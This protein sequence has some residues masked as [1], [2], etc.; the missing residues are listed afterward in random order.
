M[1]SGMAAVLLA[2][3]SYNTFIQVQKIA[4]TII[5]NFVCAIRIIKDSQILMK[6]IVSIYPSQK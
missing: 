5:Y 4:H 3:A 2:I 1:Q 6:S